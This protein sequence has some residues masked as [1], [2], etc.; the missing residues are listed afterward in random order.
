MGDKV[1]NAQKWNLRHA[2]KNAIQKEEI[3]LWCHNLLKKSAK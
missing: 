1:K 3:K 2:N